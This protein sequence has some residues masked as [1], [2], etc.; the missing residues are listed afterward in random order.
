MLKSLTT[1]MLFL[2][3]IST[4]LHAQSCVPN[5]TSPAGK[6]EAIEQDI[7]GFQAASGAIDVYVDGQKV[8]SVVAP[9]IKGGRTYV[10]MAAIFRALNADVR[11]ESMPI[12]RITAVRDDLSLTMHLGYLWGNKTLRAMQASYFKMDAAPFLAK[13]GS[14][15]LNKIVVPVSFVASATGAEVVWNPNTVPKQVQITRGRSYF[16]DWNG[17]AGTYIQ[18][19]D[20][21]NQMAFGC[22]SGFVDAPVGS[23]G[24]RWCKNDVSNEAFLVPTALMRNAC[25]SSGQAAAICDSGRYNAALAATWRGSAVCTTGAVFDSQAQ[26]CLEAGNVLGPFTQRYRDRCTALSFG[27]VCSTNR[28]SKAQFLAVLDTSDVATPHSQA[29]AVSLLKSN[30]ELFGVTNEQNEIVSAGLYSRDGSKK[31]DFAR[32]E[33]ALPPFVLSGRRQ[34]DQMVRTA[35]LLLPI[36]VRQNTAF[37]FVDRLAQDPDSYVPYLA[38]KQYVVLMGTFMGLGGIKARDDA[39]H[40]ALKIRHAREMFKL[41]SALALVKSM[42]L[43]VADVL[44]GIGDTHTD[45]AALT[46]LYNELR[47]DLQARYNR[48]MDAAGLAA[49]KRTLS[50][51]GDELAFVAFAQRAGAPIKAYV[52]YTDAAAKPR[53]DGGATAAQLVAAKFSEAGVLVTPTPSDAAFEFYVLSRAPDAVEN[54][55]TLSVEAAMMTRI[56]ALPAAR[57]AKAYIVDMRYPNGALNSDS[58]LKSCNYLG[59]SGWGTGANAIGTA[60]GTAKLLTL[61]GSRPA[62]KRLLLEAVAH[63]VFANGYFE[64]QR[65]ELK[66]RINAMSATTGVSYNHHPGYTEANVNAVYDIFQTVNSFVNERIKAHFS[67]SGCL[68]PGEAAPFQINAQLWRHFEAETHLVGVNDGFNAPGIYRKP[69]IPGAGNPME[70]VLDPTYRSGAITRVDL[71][72]LLAE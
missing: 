29:S 7:A 63:D 31:G 50:Y 56:R 68:A 21:R 66:R 19:S 24:A 39:K 32:S 43:V 53:Y 17:S 36:A 64:A 41:R 57:L 27:A 61:N 44:W 26:A 54:L 49:I 71:P 59:F 14:V 22:P 5:A 6:C 37:V 2:V 60:V 28:W 45:D 62:A 67:G 18:Y 3:L 23:E 4:Q 46:P 52:E 10:E 20:S 8:N 9:F 1:M 34:T 11:F 25:I 35:Y 72:M 55:N 51:G 58:A 42:N 47:M 65:G 33:N 69:V 48:I 40:N 13:N 15:S 38:K 16:F 12:G 30:P 70:R